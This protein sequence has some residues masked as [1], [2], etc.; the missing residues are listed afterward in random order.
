MR[1]KTDIIG[2]HP[3]TIPV[4]KNELENKKVNFNNSFMSKTIYNYNTQSS[5]GWTEYIPT[6]NN[7]NNNK[8]EKNKSSMNRSSVTHNIISNEVNM[9]SGKLPISCQQS[10]SN[11]YKRKSIC[12]FANEKID[13]AVHINKDYVAAYTSNNNIFKKYT[14][15]CTNI[16]DS[17][18]RLAI[19]KPF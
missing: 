5:K 10:R 18:H 16:C 13:Y 9:H 4:D 7:S 3:P 15:Y 17:T 8:D 14:G 11:L 2:H 6:N 1:L 12:D 19:K